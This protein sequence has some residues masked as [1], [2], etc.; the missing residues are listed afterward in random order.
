MDNKREKYG[1]LLLPLCDDDNDSIIK[2][3]V[4]SSGILIFKPYN[5]ENDYIIS[6]KYTFYTARCIWTLFGIMDMVVPNQFIF[7]F[8][9][10]EFF[11]LTCVVAEEIGFPS[12]SHT[13]S[14]G[15]SPSST[16]HDTAARIPSRSKWFVNWKGIIFGGTV[17]IIKHYSVNQHDQELHENGLIFTSIVN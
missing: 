13:R 4:Y 5:I 17:K 8:T 7:F 1:V 2:V 6:Y 14:M 11:L 16:V 3:V 15:R 12:N 9:K 10:K